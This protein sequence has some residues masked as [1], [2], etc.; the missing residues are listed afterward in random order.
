MFLHSLNN[1]KLKSLGVNVTLVNIPF[2]AT[3]SLMPTQD[4]A[5]TMLVMV[6]SF[7]KKK[8]GGKFCIEIARWT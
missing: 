1:K 2:L 4:S 3:L 7:K 5:S 6:K 8:I